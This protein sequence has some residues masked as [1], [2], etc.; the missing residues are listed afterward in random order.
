MVAQQAPRMLAILLF[1][2]AAWSVHTLWQG[3]PAPQAM[4]A[5]TAVPAD[6]PPALAADVGAIVGRHLFGDAVAS[7][8]NTPPPPTRAALVLGGIWYTPAGDAY[9]LIGEPGAAQ[10]PYRTG[11]RL[12]G[13]VELA[14]IEA[15][16]ALLRRDGKV[17]T[18]ALPRAAA[19]P[20]PTTAPPAR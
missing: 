13:G 19:V 11:D 20:Q 16:R 7:Q 4:S 2:L 8:T 3:A 17:E 1:A 18:L 9:A 5:P 12:P 14:G 6:R 15:D 10:R